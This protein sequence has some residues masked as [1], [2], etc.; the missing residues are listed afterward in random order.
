MNNINKIKYF[1]SKLIKSSNT[2]RQVWSKEGMTKSTR[3]TNPLCTKMT[4]RNG[5]L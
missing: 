3:K 1:Y 4:L 5:V 2:T